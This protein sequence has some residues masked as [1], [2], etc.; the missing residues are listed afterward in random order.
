MNKKKS[1]TSF[2]FSEEDIRLLALLAKEFGLSKTA[3][4]A[5]L[6]REEARRRKLR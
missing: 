5:F 1:R 2:T 6:L 4:I 3:T